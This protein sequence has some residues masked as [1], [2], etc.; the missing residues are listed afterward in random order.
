MRNLFQRLRG[1]VLGRREE[2]GRYAGAESAY[3]QPGIYAGNQRQLYTALDIGTEFAKA[4][5]IEVR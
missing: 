2:N 4:I 3:G 1:F 5:I